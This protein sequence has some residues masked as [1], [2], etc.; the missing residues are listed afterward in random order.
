[1]LICLAV[2]G[3]MH[4]R[5]VARTVGIDPHKTWN[6]V[7]RLCDS[8]LV[9]KRQYEGGRKY[10]SLNREA[11]CYRSLIKLLLALDAYWPAQRVE[12]PVTRRYMPFF[13]HL[14]P[15]HLDNIFQSPVRSRILLFV[16]AVGV[17]NLSMIYDMLG[18][19][20]VSVLLAVNAW[21]RQGVLKSMHVGRHRLLSLN[22]DFCVAKELKAFMHELIVD[23]SEYLGLRTAGRERMRDVRL[24]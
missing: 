15:H 13:N 18:L 8:G 2:N 10:V 14:E 9:V 21:E 19:G 4:V 23:S 17:T 16:G 22:P 6:M 24:F 7:E 3:P 20:S 11:R 5:D 12:R 1:M